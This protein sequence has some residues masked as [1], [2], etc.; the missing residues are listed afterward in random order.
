MTFINFKYCLQVYSSEFVQSVSQEF[1]FNR[2]YF[3]MCSILQ[4]TD[5]VHII[6]SGFINND[7][8][9]LDYFT[10]VYLFRTIINIY[11]YL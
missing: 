11:I 2:A 1:L 3:V 8:N 4:V 5:N 6:M 10:N 9:L 7:I